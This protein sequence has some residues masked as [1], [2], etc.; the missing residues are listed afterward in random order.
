[1]ERSKHVMFCYDASESTKVHALGTVL[2]NND[3]CTFNCDEKNVDDAIA[4][5]VE[6]AACMIIV[7]SKS[8]QNTPTC[9]KAVCYADQCKIPLLCFDDGS[10]NWKP[11]SWLG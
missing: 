6:Y 1:M 7:P 2:S 8:F 4:I 9:M 11:S 3:I 5:G 10:N